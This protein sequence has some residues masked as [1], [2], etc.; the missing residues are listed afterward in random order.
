MTESF[1]SKFHRVKKVP[2]AVNNIKI[3]GLG[4]TRQHVIDRE[5]K[6]VY[7]ATTLD[8]LKDRMLE[9]SANIQELD[10][11][12][13]VDFHCGPGNADKTVDVTMTVKE[14]D[15]TQLHA[16]TFVQGGE[17]SVEASV[18]LRNVLGLAD[19]YELQAAKGHQQSST[20]ALSALLP[21]CVGS[22]AEAEMRVHKNATS[23]TKHAS[24]VDHLQGISAH[25]RSNHHEVSYE[26]GLRDLQPTPGR[27]SKAVEKFRGPAL[28]SALKYMFLMDQRDSA[29]NPTKGFAVRSVSEIAGVGPLGANILRYV[30]HELSGM[31]VIPLSDAISIKLCA[32]GGVVLP[33]GDEW[34]S[35]TTSIAD[36]FFL[37]GPEHG[38]R[39]FRNRGV[40][41]TDVRR[42]GPVPTSKDGAGSSTAAASAEQPKNKLV[43]DYLGGDL[44]LSAFAALTCKFPNR[45]LQGLNVRGQVFVNAGNVVPLSGLG[46]DGM[47]TSAMKLYSDMR[48]TTGV[49][50][51][52]PVSVGTIELNYC[53]VH[54]WSEHDRIKRG[55]QFS[56][57]PSGGLI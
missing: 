33:W 28:K 38:L 3:V 14:R 26:L 9:A 16:G 25:L 30:R 8:E 56:V 50:L 4:R 44:K 32:S 47:K 49:G 21:R 42:Q 31:G 48:L 27:A 36:R 10:V 37:G 24:Y 12:R 2:L 40:G 23:H 6:R 41:P 17:G 18:K 46:R 22:E 34:E 5:L 43:R 13:Y 1:H 15:M 29:H 45:L 19:A 57:L 51:T 39:G 20:F 55:L 7:E 54:K 52:F 11:F 53:Q 35:K